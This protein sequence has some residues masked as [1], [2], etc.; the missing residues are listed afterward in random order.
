MCFP[1][2]LSQQQEQ[3]IST[4]QIVKSIG[5]NRLPLERRGAG[6]LLLKLL[7]QSSFSR[8]VTSR[9]IAS[10]AESEEKPENRASVLSMAVGVHRTGRALTEEER[11]GL[12]QSNGGLIGNIKVVRGDSIP[13]SMMWRRKRDVIDTK[14]MRYSAL[15]ALF[16][17]LGTLAAILQN[18]LLLQ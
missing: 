17:L 3:R 2:Q 6:S 7:P 18:E 9:V 13:A 16:G 1:L 11:T 12:K 14:K 5:R 4:R 10:L 8:K 15:A